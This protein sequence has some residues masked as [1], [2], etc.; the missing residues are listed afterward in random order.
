MILQFPPFTIDLPRRRLTREGVMV[1]LSP[2]LVDIL[3]HLASRPAELIA[4]DE[5]LDRFWPDVH[6]TENTL[7]RAIADIRKALGD[8]AG[9][10]RYIQTV[11]RRGYRFIGPL[12]TAAPPSPPITPAVHDPFLD[13]VK[14][15]LSLEMLDAEK[16]PEAVAAFER[17]VAATPNYAAAHAGLANAYFLQYELTRPLNLPDR[18]SLDR[19]IT[20]ARRACELDGNLGEAW[21]TLGFV[22]TAAGQVAAARAAARHAAVLEPSNWRHHFRLSMATWGE[23]RLSAVDRTL[24]FL[25]DFAPAR[26]VAA[27]VFIARHA[28]GPAEETA[29]KAAS[30]QTAAGQSD[31]SLFPAVGA[32]WLHGLLL[33]RRG[34]IGSAIQS[35][36]REIDESRESRVYCREFRVNAQV[37]AGF[38]HLAAN[39]PGGA[40]EAFRAALELFPHNGRALLGL[41]KAFASTSLAEEAPSLMRKVDAAV[42]ELAQGGRLAEAALIRAAADA[43]RGNGEAALATLEQLLDQAPPGQT[44][45]I[46]VVD[47]ALQ[48]LRPHPGFERL[49]ARLAARAA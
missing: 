3:A 33:L 29:A 37:A 27:M 39:D 36:A 24:N 21:A 47:P 45:W 10:P 7:T 44:G 13:W 17:A 49:L 20:H 4:K 48:D 8:E 25:P 12:D 28:L 15:R 34:Q 31:G 16:L 40:T 32:H 42:V 2:R 19:A 26:F 23:E 46:I 18:A 1:D 14:G 35:F 38:A 6:V 30:A 11:A 5:L 22:L 43:T 9:E 41:S